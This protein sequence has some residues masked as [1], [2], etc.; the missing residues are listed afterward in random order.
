VV[1]SQINF[2]WFCVDDECHMHSGLPIRD[3][4]VEFLAGLLAAERVRGGTRRRDPRAVL[5]RPG[6]ASPAVVPARY[7]VCQLAGDNT[8][9]T[10]TGYDYLHEGIDVL[11]GR[12]PS[13][14]GR[15]PASS[16]GICDVFDSHAV[17]QH[18]GY[19][20]VPTF[21]GIHEL[22]SRPTFDHRVAVWRTADACCRGA[23]VVRLAQ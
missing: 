9:G 2:T 22:G 16:D 17:A 5:L 10:S 23:G 6:G 11:A 15:C 20:A 19:E 1:F 14:Q 4:T 8:I 13:L 21:A 7:P 12:A 18:Q 3:E